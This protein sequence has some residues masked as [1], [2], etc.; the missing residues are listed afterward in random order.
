MGFIDPRVTRLSTKRYEL[1]IHH[2]DPEDIAPNG[3][4]YVVEVLDVDET[5]EFGRLLLLT[6]PPADAYGA[7]ADPNME[8]RGII[9]AVVVAVGNG[10]ML[11]LS[12][13]PPLTKGGERPWASVPMFYKHGDVVFVDHNARGRALRIVGRECRVVNQLDILCS[14]PNLRL[15]RNAEGAWEQ[16]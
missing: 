9:P 15:H 8:V 6:Q 1:K 12:D 7:L 10:H 16:E 13:L 3:D 11:G 14:L 5:M 4:R 2:L